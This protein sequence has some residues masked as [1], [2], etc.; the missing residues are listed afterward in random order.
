MPVKS[1]TVLQHCSQ[2][3]PRSAGNIFS[4]SSEHGAGILKRK[5]CFIASRFPY[6]AM[7]P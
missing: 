1:T 6:D 3:R 2:C 7:H 4:Q 5:E